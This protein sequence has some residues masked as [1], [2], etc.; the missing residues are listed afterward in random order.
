M[1]MKRHLGL[2]NL[3]MIEKFQGLSQCPGSSDGLTLEF[4]LYCSCEG[5]VLQSVL[6]YY[7]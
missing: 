7:K 2:L 4:F 5:I 1:I 6:V 3:I